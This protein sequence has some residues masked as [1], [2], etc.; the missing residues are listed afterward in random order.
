MHCILTRP[1]ALR[2][3]WRGTTCSCSKVRKSISADVPSFLSRSEIFTIK[4]INKHR[5][6]RRVISR[7]GA[8]NDPVSATCTTKQTPDGFFLRAHEQQGAQDDESIGL[9]DEDVSVWTPG[10]LLFLMLNG[11]TDC[12][13]DIASSVLVGRYADF[14]SLSAEIVHGV[15]SCMHDLLR[16]HTKQ[17]GT[18][19]SDS[20][21]VFSFLVLS[22]NLLKACCSP[23][24]I[25]SSL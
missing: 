6:F 20:H 11:V 18:Q 2:Q 25:H 12:F 5:D 16:V 21:A 4:S 24:Y 14:A 3:P 17:R 22:R 13:R 23:R 19:H 8:T 7:A 1:P 15:A 9:R 10:T